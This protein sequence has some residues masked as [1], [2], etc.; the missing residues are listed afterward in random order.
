MAGPRSV[1]IEELRQYFRLPEK[2]VAK[3]LGICLTSLKKVCR[4]NGINRWPYRKVRSRPS[5]TS[6]QNKACLLTRARPASF[7]ADEEPGQE[8]W[9]RL[10]ALAAADPSW[11]GRVCLGERRFA[12]F[13]DACVHLCALPRA[14]GPC[15][16]CQ[17]PGRRLRARE[18]ICCL[19]ESKS[20][21][22]AAGNFIARHPWVRKGA[23]L[24]RRCV[25]ADALYG[26]TDRR[27]HPTRKRTYRREGGACGN[28]G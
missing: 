17:R 25:D 26:C 16:T 20:P 1:M 12:S 27:K 24:G 2:V 6:M 8:E 13:H 19:R 3:K 10:A 28:V 23:S 5:G 22:H 18:L 4:S 7:V 21:E 9:V 14:R 11:H 15:C